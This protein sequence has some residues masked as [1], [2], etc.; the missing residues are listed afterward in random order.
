MGRCNTVDDGRRWNSTVGGRG[1]GT[2]QINREDG[3]G[4]FNGTHDGTGRSLVGGCREPSGRP[5]LIW[6]VVPENRHLYFGTFRGADARI[7][8]FRIDLDE[9]ENPRGRPLERDEDWVAVKT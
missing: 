6:F 5:H 2:I 1:E 9:I 3:D 4:N 8:G 7:S